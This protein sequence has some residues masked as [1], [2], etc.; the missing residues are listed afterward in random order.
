MCHLSATTARNSLTQSRPI[1]D[2]WCS[3]GG[4][5][6]KSLRIETGELRRSRPGC[7]RVEYDGGSRPFRMLDAWTFWSAFVSSSL[8]AFHTPRTHARKLAQS[9]SI[10]LNLVWE[11][12]GR[13]PMPPSLAFPP[14]M[15]R[16]QSCVF[17]FRRGKRVPG[18]PEDQATERRRT[19]KRGWEDRQATSKHNGVTWPDVCAIA[20]AMTVSLRGGTKQT[21]SMQA[22]GD[23]QIIGSSPVDDCEA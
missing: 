4:D 8:S 7:G 22:I 13:A 1:F 19:W 14:M 9:V 15:N 5:L 12:A 23:D 16:A 21:C 10:C 2:T 17:F 20:I 11:K 18:Y 6:R 3:G